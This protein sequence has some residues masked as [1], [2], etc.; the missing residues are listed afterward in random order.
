VHSFTHF[1]IDTL[2]LY[3]YVTYSAYLIKLR[4]A[5]SVF[6]HEKVNG[7]WFVVHQ[8]NGSCSEYIIRTVY[9][10]L[11]NEMLIIILEKL[12]D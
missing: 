5:I 8:F 1:I 3:K 11:V 6:I 10:Y 2:T 7:K 9:L 12:T 4:T